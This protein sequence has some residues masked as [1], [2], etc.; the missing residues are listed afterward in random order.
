MPQLEIAGETLAEVSILEIAAKQGLG[1]YQLIVNV[2]LRLRPWD[3]KQPAMI[4]EVQGQL[5][6]ARPGRS[7]VLIGRLHPV[8]PP[9]LIESGAKFAMRGLELEVQVSPQQM[10][11][12]EEFRDGGKLMFAADLRARVFH[13]GKPQQLGLTLSH[14]VNQVDWLELLESVGHSRT[15]LLEVPAPAGKEDSLFGKALDH[16]RQAETSIRR[17]EFRDAVGQCRDVLESLTH[18]RGEQNDQVPGAAHLFHNV[19]TMSKDERV[20]V[21]RNALRYLTHQAR[22]VDENTV[23]VEF[24]RQDASFILTMVAAV[25]RREIEEAERTS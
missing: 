10:E 12:L 21:V 16:L 3:P 14:H 5:S 4:T 11:L 18:A 17:G 7:Q 2:N 19:K 22:H 25:L 9:V 24:H 15:L 20:K 1:F 13:R 23:N 6:A 8:Y